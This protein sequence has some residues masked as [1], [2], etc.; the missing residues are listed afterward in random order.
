[1]K[2]RGEN[3][4]TNETKKITVEDIKER[5]I[6]SGDSIEL[7]DCERFFEVLENDKADG[8]FNEAKVLLGHFWQSIHL[9][10]GEL[11]QDNINAY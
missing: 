6:K 5:A 2:K 8:F 3:K 4:M 11:L 9:K 1:V 10:D 7:S